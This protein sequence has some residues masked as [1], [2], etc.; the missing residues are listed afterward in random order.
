M[1]A[2]KSI[3]RLPKAFAIV[4]QCIET[5]A[6]K[7]GVRV[8]KE[9]NVGNHLHLV[10]KLTRTSLWSPFIRELSGR[11]AQK[12][13]EEFNLNFESGFWKF[14]PHT[15]IVR[16]WKRAFRIALDYVYLNQLEG[17][18]KIDRKDIKTLAEYRA[19]FGNSC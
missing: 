16:G 9:A 12:L 4:K 5:T 10:I 13:C 19:R 11:I 18:G 15:R 3:L 7:Y 8:Y 2:E 6:N 17:E 1:R 14:R